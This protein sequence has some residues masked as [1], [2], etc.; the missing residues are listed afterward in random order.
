MDLQTYYEGFT[1]QNLIFRRLSYTDLPSWREF[2]VDNPSLVYLNIDT[3][4]PIDVMA[5]A[6]IDAQV[7]RY[8]RNEF[9]QLAV[10]LKENNQLIG[11]RGFKYCTLNGERV[12]ESA[13]SFKRKYWRQGYGTESLKRVLKYI[14]EHHPVDKIIG[15]THHQ[16]IASIKNL[17]VVGYQ[18]VT[19]C[20][21]EDR[22]TVVQQ[23]TREHWKNHQKQSLVTLSE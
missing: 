13:G 17:E 3:T 1:S 22:L 9:G 11:T 21:I 15:R 23:L 4:R 10:V 16:N 14:F 5:K 18:P 6:W 20:I 19:T 12:L 8:E 7:E 2:Y